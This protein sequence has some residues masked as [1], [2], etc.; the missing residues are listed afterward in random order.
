M[1]AERTTKLGRE[2]SSVPTKTESV[3]TPADL[4]EQPPGRRKRVLLAAPVIA[5]L[6]GLAFFLLQPGGGDAPEDATPDPGAIV[7]LEPIT[8]NLAGG[9]FLKVG[10]ALQP[11][12]DAGTEVDGA[13]A[14][15]LA[16]G[17]FSGRTLGELASREG[18]EKAKTALVRDVSQAYDGKVYDVYF[19]TFVMQ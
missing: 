19:T 2:D 17:L 12:A 10:M 8:V 4:T 9:H 5:L 11:T 15:D 6:A 13:K 3:P 16:I 18:R 1:R 14:L 7:Q